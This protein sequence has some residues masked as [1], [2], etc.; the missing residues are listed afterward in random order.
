M[1]VDNCSRVKK[2]CFH[3]REPH[4]AIPCPN[5][6]EMVKIH[7]AASQGHTS[8]RTTPSTSSHVCASS[9]VGAAI[10]A[11]TVLLLAQLVLTPPLPVA[12]LSPTLL[13]LHALT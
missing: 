10:E 11:A 7:C 13:P 9:A 1:S 8:G 3:E 2:R 12:E 4:Q 6:H 5:R